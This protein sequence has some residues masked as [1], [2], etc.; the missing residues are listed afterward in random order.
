[1]AEAWAFSHCMHSAMEQAK[2]NLTATQETMSKNVNQHWRAIDFQVGD[3][4]YLSTH[5]LKSHQPS[6]KLAD[7]WTGPFKIIKKVGYLYKLDLLSGSSIYNVF[8]SELLSKA[9][10]DLLSG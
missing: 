1:M 9:A 5:N 4:V 3:M 7:Q 2:A 10:T 6:C 8:V